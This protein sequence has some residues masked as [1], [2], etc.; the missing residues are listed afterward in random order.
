MKRGD[1]L[2]EQ[3]VD[4]ADSQYWVISG[5]VSIVRTFV[6]QELMYKVQKEQR[7]QRTMKGQNPSESVATQSEQEDMENNQAAEQLDLI[8]L[9]GKGKDEDFLDISEEESVSDSSQTLDDQTSKDVSS[10]LKV[11]PY[12][13]RMNTFNMMK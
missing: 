10:N 7:L 9:S 3:G 6:D 5:K 8:L 11:S 1:I 13:T 12:M 4:R 2:F